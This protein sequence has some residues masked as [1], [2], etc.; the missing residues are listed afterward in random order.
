MLIGT[1]DEI[2]FYDWDEV[3]SQ[4]TRHN[5][6]FDVTVITE[7]TTEEA[8][9]GEKQT[10]RTVAKAV[11]AGEGG[12]IIPRGVDVERFWQVIEECIERA[13]E[14]NRRLSN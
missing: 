6:R 9:R 7:G 2:L 12:V 8:Q 1:P 3:K 13:D 4:G 14:T 5:E 11:P 10:G